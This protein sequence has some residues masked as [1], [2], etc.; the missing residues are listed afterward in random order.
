MVSEEAGYSPHKPF[1][2]LF[3]RPYEQLEA[4]RSRPFQPIHI[5]LSISIATDI[6]A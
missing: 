4:R 6:A 5:R 2:S 3:S 1:C